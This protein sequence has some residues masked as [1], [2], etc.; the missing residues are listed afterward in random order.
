M[1]RSLVFAACVAVTLTLSLHAV[2]PPKPSESWVALEA[3]NFRF[4]SA[5]SSR[6]TLEIARDLLRLRAALGKVTNFE[7][8][9]AAPTRVF[10]FRTQH[11]FS[12][13]CE[14]MLRAKCGTVRGL[15]IDGSKG[16]FILMAGDAEGG[17][18]RVVYHELT[19]QLVANSGSRLPAWY[20]EGLAEY[21]STFR[22]VGAETH[23]GITVDAHMRWLRDE[24]G[25]GSLRKRLIPLR[26]LFAITSSSPIYDERRRTGVFYAQSWALAHYLFHDPDRREQRFHFLRLLHDGQSPEDA[27]AEA[28]GI[29]LSELEQAL[30]TYIRGGTFTYYGRDLGELTIPEL[31]APAAMPYDAVLHQL[32]YLLMHRPENRADAERFFKESLAT[33][34]ANANAHIE[35]ARLYHDAGRMEEADAAY[36]KAVEAGSDDAEV[37]LLAG[38]S[39]LDRHS[40]GLAKARPLF[41]RATELDPKSAEAWSALGAT[42]L[43]DT[44]DRAAGIAA[45]KKS[46]ELDPNGEEA[47]FYLAQLWAAEGHIAPAR[48][49]A[50]SL[51]ARTTSDSMKEQITSVLALIDMQEAAEEAVALL[52]RAAERL[53]AGRYIEALVLIDTALPKLPNEKTRTQALTLRDTI[54]AEM[55]KR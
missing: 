11:G 55:R 41:K 2:E 5:V 28:F 31:P 33:N 37:Y 25:L 52:T 17:V 43:R 34:A 36:A 42:Y 9:A 46:L 19:H 16:D 51:L 48:K 23:L 26:E 50:Q 14:A 1:P 10:V 15:F 39:I 38:R 18:D 45:L 24:M 21:F 8:Q 35:L 32:G 49:L 30:R 47:A 6:Q 20:E 7:L 22:T 13:Y 40:D 44:A 53:N 4:V 27:V 12:R 29:S 3:E 54:E